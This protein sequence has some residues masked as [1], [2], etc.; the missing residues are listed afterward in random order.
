MTHA[1]NQLAAAGYS[2][3]AGG[4]Q[5]IEA[6]RKVAYIFKSLVMPVAAMAGV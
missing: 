4:A 1:N 2:T 3:Q 5:N 6:T